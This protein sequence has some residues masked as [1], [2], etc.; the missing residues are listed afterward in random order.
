VPTGALVEG[1]KI[2]RKF[3]GFLQA[4][5]QWNPTDGASFLDSPSSRT[6]NIAA[7]DSLD[8]QWRSAHNHC[9]PSNLI[10]PRRVPH[11]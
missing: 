1:V 11:R 6:G 5:R 3:I 8:H 2:G 9:T 10:A 4:G 7:H